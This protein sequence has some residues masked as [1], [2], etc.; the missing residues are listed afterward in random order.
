MRVQDIKSVEDI[1]RFYKTNWHLC[2]VPEDLLLQA[3]E[4]G[5]K[6]QD[7][8]I[9]T[10]DKD[11]AHYLDQMYKVGHDVN[12]LGYE[13]FLL[14]LYEE[15]G[16]DGYYEDLDPKAD[17]FDQM[18]EDLE[19]NEDMVE[20]KEC[21]DLFPK[22]DCL[23]QAVGYLCPTCQRMHMPRPNFDD[24]SSR[25]ITVDL[26]DQEFPDVQD[27]DPGTTKN[28][29]E[30]PTVNDALE[31]LLTDEVEA[32]DGYVKAAEVVETQEPENAEEILDTIDH[33]K[34]EEEEHIEEI[35]DLMVDDAEAE[36]PVEVK[37]EKDDDEKDDDEKEDKSEKLDEASLTDILRNAGSEWS[38]ADLLDHEGVSDLD[39]FADYETHQEINK[40]MSSQ[41]RKDLGEKVWVCLFAGEEIGHVLAREHDEALAKMKKKFPDFPYN[42]PE[43]EDEYDVYVDDLFEDMVPGDLKEEFFKLT[44]DEAVDKYNNA[45]RYA[46]RDNVPY[47][48]GYTKEDGGVYYP[49][50]PIK[51]DTDITT[52]E[53]NLKKEHPEAATLRVAYPTKGFRES[54]EKAITAAKASGRSQVFGYRSSLTEEF[55]AMD[56]VEVDDIE[57]LEADLALAYEDFGGAEVVDPEDPEI[58]TE[59]NWLANLWTKENKNLDSVFVQGYLVAVA[60]TETVY[61]AKSFADAEKIANKASKAYNNSSIYIYG[62]ALPEETYNSYAEPIQKVIAAAGKN[63]VVA[64][65]KSGK[66]TLN[67]APDINKT[68]KATKSLLKAVEKGSSDAAAQAALEKE[69]EEL[70]ANLEQP[71]TGKA[72]VTEPEVAA[73]VAETEETVETVDNADTTETT[74]PEGEDDTEAEVEV[75]VDATTVTTEDYDMADALFKTGFLCFPSKNGKFVEL[76]TSSKAAAESLIKRSK[77]TTENQK[78]VF[79]LLAKVPTPDSFEKNGESICKELAGLA[80]G[81]KLPKELAGYTNKIYVLASYQN[82]KRLQ[83]KGQ[84]LLERIKLKAE[85]FKDLM[86][87]D[88]EDIESEAD[89][90]TTNDADALAEAKSKVIS[91]IQ[92]IVT[93]WTEDQSTYTE[94]SWSAF[95]TLVTD[96]KKAVE[97]ATSVKA[98]KPY[99]SSEKLKKLL[100]KPLVKKPVEE[101]PTEET[102]S[103]ETAAE[104]EAAAETAEVDGSKKGVAQRFKAIVKD[105]KTKQGRK[106]ANKLIRAALK[107]AGLANISPEQ[108]TAIRQQL[109]GED[110][111]PSVETLLTEAITHLNEDTTLTEEYYTD[112]TNPAETQAMED[113]EKT[114]NQNITDLLV[115]SNNMGCELDDTDHDSFWSSNDEYTFHI[116]VEAT[117]D[118]YDSDQFSDIED[119]LNAKLEEL[120]STLTLPKELK[121]VYTN[122]NFPDFDLWDE[123]D[124]DLARGLVEVIV[125]FPRNLF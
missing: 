63:T 74:D 21:F 13:D 100:G 14:S 11:D 69:A 33:I 80:K 90:L 49:T 26:Y 48:Y 107:N 32:V 117:E 18:V 8:P 87:E 1:F 52:F 111:E 104:P 53:T 19:L 122:I 124:G 17:N 27:Y 94:E 76:G 16:G 118:D 86:A 59:A 82:T 83:A 9:D 56:P 99:S 70:A 39:G 114:M 40:D 85:M 57:E 106:N 30:E 12:Y 123:D 15:D 93:S 24:V 58:L 47:L 81:L 119:M 45:I 113:F 89:V 105:I 75:E 29:S 20:C 2:K 72:N 35:K 31:D 95:E 125:T 62:K 3:F 91:G 115:F 67:K 46:K 97:D 116:F 6:D 64:A 77:A 71:S 121:E 36:E 96:T 25:D 43:Y 42:S 28:W 108:L 66:V 41:I 44:G 5:M 37:D 23:K 4:A 98:L 120:F 79:Y 55:V 73:V 22:V 112:Y 88:A 65:Y 102:P 60:G 54:Y 38:E 101:T 68:I 92:D 110:L 50:R 78:K 7:F 61:E 109:L 51:I 103:T 34:E 84:D 10:A